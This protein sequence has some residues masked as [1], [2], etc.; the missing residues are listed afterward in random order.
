M[1]PNHPGGALPTSDSE[2]LPA[3]D[4]GNTTP[5]KWYKNFAGLKM[6]YVLGGCVGVHALSALIVFIANGGKF[7]GGKSLVI[8]GLV[9]AV[10]GQLAESASKSS[11]AE[12]K[13]AFKDGLVLFGEGVKFYGV[14]ATLLGAI[15]LIDV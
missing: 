10:V 5:P 11:E 12:G 8:V 7:V 4:I 14:L 9:V 2:A 1:S 15:F 3:V 13:P 6:A